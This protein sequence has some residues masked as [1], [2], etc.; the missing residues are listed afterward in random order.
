MEQLDESYSC[1]LDLEL[2]PKASDKM[3]I[4]FIE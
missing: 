4:C 3:F 1:D 2:F